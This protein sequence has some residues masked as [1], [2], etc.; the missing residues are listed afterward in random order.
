MGTSGN[1]DYQSASKNSY[2]SSIM[3]G[4]D[5]ME[6]IGREYQETG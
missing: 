6:K 5:R 1:R 2:R 3:V 4:Y